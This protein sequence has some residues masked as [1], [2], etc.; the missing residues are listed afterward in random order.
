MINSLTF[1]KKVPF[2][3]TDMAGIVH[4]SRIL[5]YVEEAE[6]AVMTGVGVHAM[7]R[8]GGY[9]KVHVDCDYHAPLRF[10]DEVSIDLTLVRLGGKSLTWKFKVRRNEQTAA[11]GG[12]TTVYTDSTGGSAEIPSASRDRLESFVEV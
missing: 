11:Q 3:D 7:T 12:F 10:D 6:H 5:C 2:A 8:E 4:F 9:P 1:Q